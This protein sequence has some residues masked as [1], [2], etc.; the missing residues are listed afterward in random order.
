MCIT[1]HL[2][3]LKCVCHWCA[4]SSRSDCSASASVGAMIRRY[5][6]QS[7]ANSLMFDLTPSPMS[8]MFPV[9][10]PGRVFVGVFAACTLYLHVHYHRD[11]WLHGAYH[12]RP[13][14]LAGCVG[15]LAAVCGFVTYLTL[16]ITEHQGEW[17]R[18][19]GRGEVRKGRGEE[20][21]I[22]G[23]DGI[24]RMRRRVV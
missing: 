7:S 6:I 17:A 18:G 8:L 4:L 16:A 9:L 3:T 21:A 13:Y 24:V 19:R 14:M 5:R 12:L 15:Q 23:G 22:D 10:P 2:L 1:E 11:A 20:G